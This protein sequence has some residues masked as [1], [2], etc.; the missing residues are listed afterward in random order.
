MSNT[1]SAKKHE[2]ILTVAIPA[3]NVE[4]YIDYCLS[5]FMADSIPEDD[6]E[7]LIV[8]DGSKD[9]TEAIAKRYEELYPDVFRV[10]TKENGGHGSAI[11]TGLANASGKYFKIVDG[12]DWVDYEQF[13]KYIT[14]LRETDADLVATDFCCVS[15]ETLDV[16]DTRSPVIRGD[17]ISGVFDF[18]SVCD[19]LFVRMHS[20]TWRT[21]LLRERGIRI[22]EGRFYVDMEYILFP[23]PYVQTVCIAHLPVYMYRLGMGGQS[24]SIASMQRNIQHHLDVMNA[25]LNHLDW[26][27]ETGVGARKLAYLERGIAQMVT[28]QCQI[29]LSYPIF[30]GMKKCM[31]ELDRMLLQKYPGVYNAVTNKYVLLLRRTNYILF[32]IASVAVRLLKK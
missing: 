18:D 7:V 5:S 24:V 10:I 15:A 8:N 30:S 11:N 23:I 28:M 26:C 20:A 4:N 1:Y 9:N 6:L 25:N 29:Y 32:P 17:N 12:D 22:D 3:Y 16:T 13:I 19:N 2:K 14:L 31:Q 21:S 27:R